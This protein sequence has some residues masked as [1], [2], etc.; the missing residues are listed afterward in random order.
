M[1]DYQK[2]H[3]AFADFKKDV[4][5]RCAEHLKKNPEL[6]E[7]KLLTTNYT[8]R[9]LVLPMKDGT[10]CVYNGGALSRCFHGPHAHAEA[11]AYAGKLINGEA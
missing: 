6:P 3:K 8:N 9:I 1:I 2:R 10:W 7:Q 5:A 4:E 11:S